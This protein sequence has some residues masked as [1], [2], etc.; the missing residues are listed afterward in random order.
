V[1][2]TDDEVIPIQTSFAQAV[3]SYE[4]DGE[5][6]CT[7]L[8]ATCAFPK[9]SAEP[10]EEAVDTPKVPWKAFTEGLPEL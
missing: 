10:C 2:T 8:T 5:E 4:T 6:V 3:D 7:Y 1:V 9:L